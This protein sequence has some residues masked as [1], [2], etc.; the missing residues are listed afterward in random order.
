L[1]IE[2][3]VETADFSAGTELLLYI[4][5]RNL[6]ENNRAM[7]KA[8]MMKVPPSSSA[9]SRA[10]K[11]PTTP[12]AAVWEKRAIVQPLYTTDMRES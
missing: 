5:G 1:E 12:P 6:E 2:R 11:G 7:G 8:K 9:L 10:K 4:C 3:R